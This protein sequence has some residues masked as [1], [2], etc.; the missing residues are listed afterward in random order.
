MEKKDFKTINFKNESFKDAVELLLK[1]DYKVIISESQSQ[2]TY[3]HY[4]KDNK[5]G[6]VQAGQWGGIRICTVHK[7][8]RNVGTGY[9]LN[10]EGIFEFDL[11]DL[12]NAFILA[13]HWANRKD[14]PFIKKYESFEEYNALP[15]NQ[16]TK[17]I[18][19]KY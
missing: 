4:W 10:D 16:I 15:I 1:N 14:I 13:P 12:E 8:N 3:A 18:Q 5:V 6:Y 11:K 7:P 2:K 17:K 9:S 19:V